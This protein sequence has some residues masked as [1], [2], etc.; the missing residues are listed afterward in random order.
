MKIGPENVYPGSL[1]RIIA[2]IATQ[3]PCGREALDEQLFEKTKLF[4]NP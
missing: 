2:V 3:T 1:K 4:V